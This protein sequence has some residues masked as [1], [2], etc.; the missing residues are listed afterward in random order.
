[1]L[2]FLGYG[3]LVVPV[4][5]V[6]AALWSW[7]GG[8][9]RSRRFAVWIRYIAAGCAL[10]GLYRQAEETGLSPFVAAAFVYLSALAVEAQGILRGL[11]AGA[12]WTGAA[13]LLLPHWGLWY[14][15]PLTPAT[16]LE[17]AAY[18]VAA[19]VGGALTNHLLARYEA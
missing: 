9:E 13:A 18:L 1:M 14:S 12:G 2:V 8:G 3:M 19:A 7:L 11:L 15:R 17:D 16:V 6:A 4:S 10:T 5:A